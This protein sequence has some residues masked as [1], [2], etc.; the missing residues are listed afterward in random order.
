MNIGQ[1]IKRRREQ[2]GWTQQQLSDASG[3]G[4]G[5]IGALEVRESVRSKYL[6]QLAM[7]MGLTVDQL[8][9]GQ[10]LPDP[11][12][13]PAPLT[14]GKVPLISEVQAG[15][16]GSNLE[17]SEVGAAESWVDSP[18]PIQART[19]AMRVRGD[20]MTSTGREN[21]PDGC[22]IYVEPSDV[23]PLDEMVGKFVVARLAGE[24]EA[25]FKKLVKDRGRFYLHPLNPQFEKIEM[26]ENT[27][28][29]G[30]VKAKVEML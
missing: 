12:V 19:F 6:P 10:P 1:K 21:F 11:N 2:L 25:T 5:T 7:A 9:G 22:I 28:I 30:V 14:L 17:I 8:T 3:V 24:E 16:W 18:I 26:P 27:L 23:R 13:G 15:L 4:K 20:S 29:I